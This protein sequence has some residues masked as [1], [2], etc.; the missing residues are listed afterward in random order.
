MRFRGHLLRAMLRRGWDVHAAA[1]GLTHDSPVGRQLLAWG[2]E[3]HTAP[4]DR[5]GMSVVRDLRSLAAL[6]HLMRDIRPDAFLGYTIKPVIYGSLAARV[7]GV[8]A[9]FALITGRGVIFAD[10]GRAEWRQEALSRVVRW[11]YRL[12]LRKAACVVFQNPDDEMFFRERGMVARETRTA[13]VNGSGVDLAEFPVAPLP[14]GPP[15][16]LLIARLLRSK[17]ILDFVEVARRIRASHSDT[18]F[19]VAGW[20]D[21]GPDAI[22]GAELQ[23]WIDEGVIEY[24][25]RLS[26][27][28]P[29]IRDCSVFVLPSYAEGTPRTVLEA[30]SM[31][32]AIVTSDAPGCRETVMDGE[33]GFLVPVRSP[34][35]LE[36]ALRRFVSNPELLVRM[37]ASARRVAEEKYDVHEVNAGLLAEIGIT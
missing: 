25:G 13:V 35:D 33:N 34:D 10:R 23:A 4:V 32:R 29:A 18:R 12:A 1:P 20:L 3:V 6:V 27:V 28:R 19:A 9:T 11:L 21:T 2:V 31:G 15:R 30:M 5:T 26:D 22:P 8:Q 36:N 24:L 37:G 7:A 17:G 16:F 14:E